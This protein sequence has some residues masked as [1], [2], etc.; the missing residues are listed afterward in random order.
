MT[1]SFKLLVVSL[2]LSFLSLADDKPRIPI[3]PVQFVR[4]P[5]K[6]K[7]SDTDSLSSIFRKLL[8]EAGGQLPEFGSAKAGIS[9]LKRQDC[10]RYD[11][12]LAQLANFSSVPYG[13]YVELDYTD[14]DEAIASGR[15]VQE[16]GKRI[17]D[18]VTVRVPKAPSETYVDVSTRA[19]RQFIQGLDISTLPPRAQ[20]S[21]AVDTTA[22]AKADTV[23]TPQLPPPPPMP[24][25]VETKTASSNALPVALMV[26]GGAVAVV[27]GIFFGVGRN[28]ASAF[29]LNADGLVGVPST[30]ATPSAVK[31]ANTKQA[32]GVTALTAGLALAAGGVFWYLLSSN[33]TAPSVAFGITPTDSGVTAALGGQF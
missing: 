6:A 32:F 2:T 29:N 7:P 26:G 11:E 16:D 8:V 22:T 14:K 33:H 9:D 15:I 4:T 27:G 25:L 30:L 19:F 10:F 17:R 31:S 12:C 13:L 23:T 24:P 3:F 1:A 20:T 21:K 18:I 5:K 28:E